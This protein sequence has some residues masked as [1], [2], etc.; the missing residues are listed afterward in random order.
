[1]SAPDLSGPFE[2]IEGQPRALATLRAAVSRQKLAS[3][4]LFEGPS[5]V[6]KAQ[7]ALAL[8]ELVLASSEASPEPGSLAHRIEAGLH[9]DV[10][11]F[12]PRE[13]GQRN[14]RVA[15]VRE[16][17]L[18]YAQFA[19]FE[20]SDAFLVFPDADVSFPMQQ[21]DGA[22]ALLKTLEE[23]R[24]GVHFI[25]LS[26]RPERL[27]PTI[28]SRCQRVS[29]VRLS[30]E[31]IDRILTRAGVP[32]A[33]RIVVTALA[34]GRA[35]KALELATR[36]EAGRSIAEERFELALQADEAAAEGRPADVLAIAE[37]LGKRADLAGTLE[38][39]TAYYRDVARAALG[40][41]DERLSFRHEA[42]RI[43]ERAEVVGARRAAEAVDG[44]RVV[45][46][47]LRRN[48]HKELVLADWLFSLG[49]HPTP[50]RL[51]RS[52]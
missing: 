42:P 5:G 45:E 26:S 3:A 27:L 30:D 31:A 4:Y 43:R 21:P 48:A 44:L 37:V 10:R 34:D 41:S 9:P 33:T 47:T 25:L 19:P 23:P 24:P 38:V 7:A 28:R 35:D 1:M 32:E 12:A 52:R 16:E 8:A 36:D 22:N 50:R 51:S 11:V 17:I 20:S 39:L 49:A 18:P 6:G 13:D 15:F 14:L 46:E 29:F 2:R 40:V